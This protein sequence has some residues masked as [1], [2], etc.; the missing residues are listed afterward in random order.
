MS[1]DFLCVN[2][3]TI[4]S[5]Y[6]ILRSISTIEIKPGTQYLALQP[7]PWSYRVVGSCQGNKGAPG[8][9]AC[10]RASSRILAE[11]RPFHSLSSSI[12]GVPRSGVLC[13]LDWISHVELYQAGEDTMHFPCSLSPHAHNGGSR[14]F[15]MSSFAADDKAE[16]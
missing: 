16:Y 11:A 1:S 10:I 14:M 3:L 5:R 2:S 4:S 13:G 7:C 9:H 8:A 15:R 12:T 6:D